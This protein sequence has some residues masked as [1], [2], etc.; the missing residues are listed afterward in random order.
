MTTT[1]PTPLEEE[2]PFPDA[3]EATEDASR[4]LEALVD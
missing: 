4:T 2:P 3:M 1:S